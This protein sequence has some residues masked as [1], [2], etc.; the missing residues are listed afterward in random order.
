[1]KFAPV[2]TAIIAALE[3]AFPS[4][5]FDHGWSDTSP[6]RR[7]VGFVWGVAKRENTDNTLEEIIEIGIRLFPNFEAPRGSPRDASI[8]EDAAETLQSA[9]A[10]SQTTLPQAEGCWFMRVTEVGTDLELQRVDGT[11]LV[12]AWNT[13][14]LV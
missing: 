6:D 9:L 1:M 7:D 4:Y 5:D 14:A 13:F 2:C 12:W 8:F 3:P 10:P 11:V